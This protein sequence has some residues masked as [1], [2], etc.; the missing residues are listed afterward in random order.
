MLAL[1]FHAIFEGLAIGLEE[2]EDDIWILYAGN[3]HFQCYLLFK[4][5]DLFS[6]SLI[7][8]NKKII[9]YSKILKFTR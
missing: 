7:E 4:I 5:A 1:S 3:E 2:H 9:N 6:R 8:L